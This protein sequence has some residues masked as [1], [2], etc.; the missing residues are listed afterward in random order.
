MSNEM[1]GLRFSCDGLFLI[2]NGP[3]YTELNYQVCTLAGAK[4]G[5][6]YVDGPDYLYTSFRYRVSE[7]WLDVLGVFFFWILFSVLA[8]WAM[9]I[10]EFGKGGF[11]TNVFERPN[12][13]SARVTAGA[14]VEPD[15]EQAQVLNTY[16]STDASVM[17]DNILSEG[18]IKDNLVKG[19]T[20]TWEDIDYFVSYSADPSGKK[21][22]LTKVAGIVK[23]G[24]MTALMGSTGS[25]KTTLLDV[26]AQ[27]KSIGTVTGQ[28]EVDGLPLRRDFQRTTGYCEQVDMQVPESTVREALQFSAR[29]RQPAEVSET[30]KDANVEEIIRVLELE[31]IA[32]AIIGT[33]E[34]GIGIS[35]EERKRVNI[36][37]ELVAKP[38]LLF[39]DEP[40][41]GLDAQASYSIIR[42]M[43]KLANQGQ[44][45]LCT[46][47]QPSS[48][49]FAYFDDLL[50]L[51]N[52]GC[53]VFFGEPGPD[54]TGLLNYFEK[55]GAPTCA[56][57]ANPAE[58]M[59]DVV[60]ARRTG[61]NWPEIWNRSP[62]RVQLLEEIQ[63]TR[64]VLSSCGVHDSS[65]EL[66]YA[67]NT[68]TQFKYVFSRMSK[69]F[70]RLPGY[71]FGRLGMLVMFAL[72]N[73]FTFYRLG[74]SIADLQSR[75]FVAFQVLG[76]SYQP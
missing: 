47:H 57:D 28:I 38:K 42:F 30:E 13:T 19:S 24:T 40:T 34:S 21:Q 44:A 3:G 29:L 20:L 5:R 76:K 36:G 69:T 49:L 54:A 50:L 74:D 31:N 43:R 17:G 39:L 52:D 15:V 2:P 10:K 55:N 71:N 12:R 7:M 75:V 73:A 27:R 59:L 72:L 53:T 66:E 23:P 8:V 65:V 56:A 26:L 61:L 60:N 18:V 48:Q 63:K 37:A 41:S 6:D 11:S 70:W 62:E 58:Y 35:V 25:G 22:L 68:L 46:V 51:A 67:T 32:D 4:P 1:S 16:P 64:T 33:T 14:P 45:I 9:D